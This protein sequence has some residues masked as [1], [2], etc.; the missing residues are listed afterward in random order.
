VVQAA[1][2]LQGVP[3]TMAVG[4][5]DANIYVRVGIPQAGNSG[6]SQLQDVRAGLPGGALTATF[7]TSD[8]ATASLL[9]STL[10]AGPT[11]SVQILVGQSNTPTSV[12]AGGVGLRR[13]AAGTATI[14]A[15]I[16]GL[17]ATT[18]ASDV[19]TVQ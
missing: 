8:Q 17:I 10:P 18:N 7:N 11:Q 15:T 4:A 13:V 6:L 19:V 9:T 1:L 12:I 5:S 16:P 3:T 2:D 14:S